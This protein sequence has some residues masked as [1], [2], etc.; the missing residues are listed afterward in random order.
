M[1]HLFDTYEGPFSVW[2]DEEG[3]E[4]THD[5]R[6]SDCPSCLR[7]AAEYGAAAAMRCAA[8]EALGSSDDELRA[9]RDHA[10]AQLTKVERS[11]HAIGFFF[12]HGCDRITNAK[13]AGML[14][15]VRLCT[16]CV[17]Q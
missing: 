9:E 5:P 14:V 6:D 7:E 17:P 1:K 8:V 3:G 10:L 11:L 2:C 12:C 13:D 16:T 4:G 15:P